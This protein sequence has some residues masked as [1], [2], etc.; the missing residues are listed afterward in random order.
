MQCTRRGALGLAIA[1]PALALLRPA[2]AQAWPSS[3]IRLVSASS[4]G[5]STDLIARVV[6]PGIARRIGQ[7]II[8]DNRPGAGRNIAVGLLHQAAPDGHTI[9]VV[10]GGIMTL[11]PHLYGELPFDPVRDFR[12]VSRLTDR[13]RPPGR[14]ALGSSPADLTAFLTSE[15][16]RVTRVIRR[17]DIRVE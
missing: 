1:L 16:Q 11:N 2:L 3:P 8:V 12:L 4:V 14:H 6:E 7:P 5:S 17:A 10:S 9:M 15:R 13:I